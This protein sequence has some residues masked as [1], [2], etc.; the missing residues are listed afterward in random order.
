M[1]V[2]SIRRSPRLAAKKRISRA[3]SDSSEENNNSVKNVGNKHSKNNTDIFS[4][5][6]DIVGD[7][8]DFIWT[9]ENEPH[10]SRRKK[11]IKK[12]GKDITK[13]TGHEPLTKYIVCFLMAIQLGMAYSMKGQLW[14]FK[15]WIC[16]YVLGATISQ[17]L[18]LAAHEISHNLAFKKFFNNKCFG[19]FTNLPMVLP[20]FISF[21][22][23]HMDHHKYQG[24]DHLD[25]DIPSPIEAKL[26]SNFPGKLVFLFNQTW[27]YAFRPLFVKPQKFTTWHAINFAIQ[28]G[29]DAFVIKYWGLHCFLYLFVSVHFAGSIH[30]SASHFIAEHYVFAEGAETHSYYGLLNLLCFNVGYHNEH[31]DFPNVAWSSLPKLRTV[32][33]E[34][35]SKLPYHKSWVKVLFKFLF[36]SRISLY[37]RARR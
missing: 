16:A 8:N 26:L 31:H 15:F 24:D 1:V 6:Y 19:I 10:P 9:N 5:E 36:D 25:T 18:F 33:D 32:A 4:G 34:E 13:L 37:N 17:A 11:L 21:K 7:L 28:F 23:Y 27:F 20:F 30:P 29:F 14:T 2:T 12:Y 22:G 35:Y 3:N